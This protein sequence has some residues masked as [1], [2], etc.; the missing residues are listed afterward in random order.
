[1]IV[2]RNSAGGFFSQKQ[3]LKEK[4]IDVEWACQLIE[5][6]QNREEN[7]VISVSIGDVDAGFVSESAL[8]KADR[9]INPSSVRVIAKTALLPN[10]AISVNRSM[11]SGQKD[12]LRTVLVQLAENDPALRALGITGFQAAEDIDYDIIRSLAEETL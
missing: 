6:A 8:K 7:V 9:Y 5:A 11:P 2:S 1:M 10:W 4:G 3:T 12:D